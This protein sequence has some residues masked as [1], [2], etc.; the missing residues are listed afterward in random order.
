MEFVDAELNDMF[1]RWFDLS[2]LSKRGME[3]ID[4]VQRLIRELKVSFL[5]TIRSNRIEGAGVSS[6]RANR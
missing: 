5:H 1:V 2:D 6:E 3:R 4:D